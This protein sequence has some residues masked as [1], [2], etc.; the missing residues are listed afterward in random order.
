LK[1]KAS[2][3]IHETAGFWTYDQ[4]QEFFEK[5]W[6]PGLPLDMADFDLEW[7]L[8]PPKMPFN[9]PAQVTQSRSETEKDPTRVTPEQA[10]FLNKH[11]R[12]LRRP[13]L[14]FNQIAAAARFTRYTL[15]RIRNGGG[16]AP[17]REAL[18]KVLST[19]HSKNFTFIDLLKQDFDL[20]NF[21]PLDK[22]QVKC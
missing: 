21:P 9:Q 12:S 7:V 2:I 6:I 1:K 13:D 11:I 16:S 5:M 19:R 10:Q 3:H 17:N 20:T 18:A 8:P 14:N 4:Y 15:S 22:T